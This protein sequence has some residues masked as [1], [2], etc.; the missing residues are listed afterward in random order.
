MAQIEMRQPGRDA[1][2]PQE[3][4]FFNTSLAS[5]SPKNHR[6]SQC[7]RLLQ[8]LLENRGRWVPLPEI[9]KVAGS[10]QSARIFELRRD[11]WRIENKL[12]RVVDGARHTAFRI[13]VEK[14]QERN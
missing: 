11:G 3:T 9:L 2:T 12:L 13:P 6:T 10:Q 14:S 8:L 7:E 1:R 5:S 4:T